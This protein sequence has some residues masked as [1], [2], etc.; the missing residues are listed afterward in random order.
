MKTIRTLNSQ[1]KIL[2]L[3]LAIHTIFKIQEKHGCKR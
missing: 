2:G 1:K 3:W